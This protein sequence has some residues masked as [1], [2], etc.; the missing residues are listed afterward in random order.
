MPLPSPIKR[1]NSFYTRNKYP[2]RIHH[3]QKIEW[4]ENISKS[5]N[6]LGK[7]MKH[8]VVK[9]KMLREMSEL[10]ACC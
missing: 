6:T 1:R 8:N 5:K 2:N 3:F 10:R 4:L 9:N 7:L